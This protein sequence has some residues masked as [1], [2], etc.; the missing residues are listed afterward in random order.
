MSL[1][2]KKLLML[3]LM[4]VADLVI[5]YA[6][7]SMEPPTPDTAITL[8]VW[9]PFILAVN[10]IAAAVAARWA[11]NFTGLFLLNAVIAPVVF[12]CCYNYAIDRNRP[13]VQ[14]WMSIAAVRAE[15]V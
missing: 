4:L 13:V 3:L 9:M 10:L 5:S 7:L 6:F 11:G 2:S 8:I 15:Q 1:L 14:A 12:Y